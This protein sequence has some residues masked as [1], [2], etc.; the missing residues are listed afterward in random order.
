ML[1][2]VCASFL[3]TLWLL[4]F[5]GFDVTLPGARIRSNNPQRVFAITLIA[6]IGFFLAGGRIPVARIAAHL[7]AVAAGLGRYPGRVALLMAI[8]S[9]MAAYAGSTR[10]AG[11]PDAF[12]YVSQADLWLRGNLK[13]PQPWV[14]NVPW[15]DAKWTFTPLGYRPGAAADDWSIVPTYSPGLPMLMAVAKRLGGQ[16]AMFAVVPL[17]SGLAVLATYGLGCRLNA[18]TCGLIAAWLVATSPVVLGSLEPLSDVPAMA[19]WTIAWYFLLGPSVSSAAAA[20]LCAALAI[21]IRPNLVPLAAPMGAWFLL[22]RTGGTGAFRSRLVPTAAFAVGV[23]IGVGAIAL[24]NQQLYGSPATSGYGRLEDQF[25]WNRVLPNLRRYLAWFTGIQTPV[26]LVGFVALLFPARR[27][28]PDVP[29]RRA[30]VVIGMFVAILWGMYCAYLEFDSWGYLRFVLPSWAFIMLG[31]GAV[32]LAAARLDGTAARWL[33]GLAVVGLGAWTLAVA[34]WPLEVYAARQAARH[35]APL[36]RLLREHTPENS[37]V[38]AFERSGSLRYYGGRI[39]LRYDLLDREWLDRAVAWLG[40]RGVRVYAVLDEHHA[41]DVKQRFASQRTAAVFDYPFL[42][43]E[44]A[45]T[46][47]FDLSAPVD[48]SRPRIVIRDAF[49]DRPGCDPPAPLEPLALR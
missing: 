5:G 19:A 14:R 47:F 41:A 6:L 18:R 26:A 7:R 46:S 39:T 38:L 17:L 3:W 34:V 43:Y 32:F 2:I 28:W 27:L 11:G 13:V 33:A 48:P 29:D 36:G 35:E 15:P 20:G 40:E 8:G 23:L 42:T 24:I 12:G 49:S 30:F 21:L 9:A 1:L 31:V 44:P 37:V 25:A 22:R 10:I 45:G 4:A 16:C